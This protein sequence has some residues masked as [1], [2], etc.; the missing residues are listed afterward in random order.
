[1]AKEKKE[2][3][4]E[5]KEEPNVLSRRN[6]FKVGA[7]TAAAGAAGA[8]AMPQKAVAKKL[9]EEVKKVVVKEE[10]DFPHEFNENYKPHPS[11][12]SVHGHAFFGRALQALGVDV[13]ME[14]VEQ[15]DQLLQSINYGHHNDKPG[16][17]QISKAF[18]GGAWAISNAGGGP[19]PGAVG[20]FGLMSWDNNDDKYPLALMDLNYVK[21]EK[22]KFES[23]E[24]AAN[25][26]KRAARL[27]GADLV[28]I[29]TQ[30]DRFDYSVQFNPVPPA[31]RKIFPMGPKQLEGMQQ[32]GGEG[33]KQAMESHTP[34]KWLHGWEKAGFKPK[35]V[36]V[37]AFEMDYEGMSAASSEISA[38]AV[39][40]GYSRMTKVAHQLAVFF[41]QLG[42][43]AIPSGND[44]GMSIPY[45]IK[46]GLGEGSRMGQ[47]VTYK[48]GPRVR[49][50]KVYTDF[51][52]VEYDKAKSFGVYEF[53]KN[54]KR[55]ADACPGKA[56]P[57]EEEP[58]FEPTHEHKDNAYFNAVGAKK[59]YLDS[60]KCFEQWVELGTDCANCITSC[61]YNKPDFWHHRLVDSINMAM[62][63]PVH[64]FM[65]EMDKVFGYGNVDDKEA[66]KK[67]IDPKGKDYDGFGS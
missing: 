35:T 2:Q 47:L 23:K 22:A 7:A 3:A 56:I 65:R 33:M 4:L 37:L 15:G 10:D 63:G 45:A 13:D 8:A 18:V 36:V 55:C 21:K 59:W 5:K 42:Y 30:D 40:E 61:P 44:T 53:C 48:Y 39:G 14:A 58:T 19:M 52:F 54:C 20:D 17:D 49:L 50:A 32:M 26:I 57:F 67:F 24:Q 29:T 6:F 46:A 25:T 60:K 51:D 9:D 38:A 66:L 11:Y 1:M 12:A 62:P 41:R 16:F 34:D 43:K 27:Y 28:G 31:A 64:S